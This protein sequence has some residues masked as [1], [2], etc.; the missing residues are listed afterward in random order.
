MKAAARRDK[1][2]RASMAEASFVG[3]HS[4]NGKELDRYINGLLGGVVTLPP[5]A[6]AGV[7]RAASKGLATITRAQFLNTLKGE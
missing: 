2:A 7:V 5:E 6:L 1:Q 4:E 3:T